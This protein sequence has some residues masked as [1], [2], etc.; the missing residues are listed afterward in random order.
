MVQ[1]WLLAVR[2]FTTTRRGLLGKFST[3]ETVQQARPCVL[4]PLMA[5]GTG[6]AEIEACHD[7]P[8]RA[9]WSIGEVGRR[10]VIPRARYAPPLRLSWFDPWQ[11][12]VRGFV[13]GQVGANDPSDVG[14][15]G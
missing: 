2:T 15:P 13:P 14:A 6:P 9:G 4:W 7:R 5:D 11:S 10:L 3:A 8:N 12:L 1:S